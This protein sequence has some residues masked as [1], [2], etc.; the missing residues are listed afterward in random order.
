MAGTSRPDTDRTG[1]DDTEAKL[2][3]T[4]D[5]FAISRTHFGT[6]RTVVNST[7]QRGATRH[8]HFDDPVLRLHPSTTDRF[9]VTK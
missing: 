4:E 5:E 7:T 9:R 1:H 8:C 6:A 2:L 3:T